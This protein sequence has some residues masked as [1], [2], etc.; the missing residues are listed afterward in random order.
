MTSPSDEP[1]PPY[2]PYGQQPPGQQPYGQQP[3]GQQPYGQ[4]PY[5][6]QPYGQQ[7][8]GA[9]VP[10]YGYPP[11]AG[12]N[13]LAIASLVV[14]ILSITVCAGFTGFVGAIL[15]H[16]ARGQ[17]KRSGEQGGGLAMAG[18]IIGWLGTVFFVGVVIVVIA[19]GVFAG[20][21]DCTGTDTG[22][23]CN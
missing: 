13:S 8:Y 23:T 5:A 6:Q 15:G 14:S 11:V 7:P 12:T 1:Q 17:M 22:Y 4:Q 19:I 10:P 20:N 9:G 16:M 21:L 18:I 3:Y 2:Q